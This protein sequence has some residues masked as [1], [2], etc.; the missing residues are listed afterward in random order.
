[1]GD[2]RIETERL[3]LREWRE[4]DAEA[5]YPFGQDARTMAFLGPLASREKTQQLVAGQM[6]NQSL[7]GYCFWPIERRS[8]GALLGMCGL[9]SAPAK[10]PL[11]ECIEIGWRL[12]STHWGQGYALEAAQAALEWGWANLDHD[13]IWS[14]TVPANAASWGLMIR[15]GM[16]RE[17]ARDFDHR[18]LGAD[19]PLRAHIVYSIERPARFTR[20]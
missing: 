13:T 16:K 11:E 10:T 6:L 12:A 18:A 17:P 19:D 9:Q 3:V 20:S 15:L 7:F 8:D 14:M 2:F 4:D 1:M 5:L